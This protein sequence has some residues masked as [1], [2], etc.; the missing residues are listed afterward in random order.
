M[1][2]HSLKV[3]GD[4]LSKGV[5]KLFLIVDHMILLI[6]ASLLP[7]IYILIFHEKLLLLT[8]PCSDFLIPIKLHIRIVIRIRKVVE[9]VNDVFVEIALVFAGVGVRG[10]EFEVGAAE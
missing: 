8:A 2:F 10:G 5:I 3:F 7:P 9:F 6:V 1:L 4:L